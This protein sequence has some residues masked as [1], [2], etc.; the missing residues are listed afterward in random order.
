MSE[1]VFNLTN[2]HL[3][4]GYDFAGPQKVKGQDEPIASYRVRMPGS[5][6]RRRFLRTAGLAPMA[7]RPIRIVPAATIRQAAMRRS[8][9]GSPRNSQPIRTAK[10]TL[11]SLSAVIGPAGPTENAATTRP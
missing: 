8:V 10:M 6:A 1:T 9:S 2:R 4:F 5:A 11:V 3:A 7:Q